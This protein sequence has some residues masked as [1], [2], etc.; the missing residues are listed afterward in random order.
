MNEE[1]PIILTEDEKKLT[2]REYFPV[3]RQLLILSLILVFLFSG[4]LVPK[5]GF[6]TQVKEE[7]KVASV[8]NSLPEPTPLSSALEVLTLPEVKVKGEAAVV[9]DVRANK[10][11]YEKNPDS[12][13]PLASIT[14][15]MT[16]LLAYELAPEDKLITI[17]SEAERQQSG[18]TLKTGE[19]FETKKL[20]DFALISSYNSA[21]Y[22]LADSIGRELSTD[23]PVGHFVAGMNVKAEELKFS[24]F[25]F[26]N[27]TGLD[28]S[29]TE[30]GAYGSAREVTFLMEYLLKE[31]PEVLRPTIR[32]TIRLYNESGDFHEA[33]NTNPL[34]KQIP[35]LLGTKTGFTDLAGG[36]LTVAFDAGFDRPI[37]VT[38]LGSSRDG[39]FSDVMSLVEAVTESLKVKQ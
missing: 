33:Q 26:L 31:Y 13:L 22:T 30:A 10:I 36:N 38:V 15:L 8:N 7:A 6:L 3:K 20:A 1:T 28:I 14:K 12:I 27:P 37:I 24:T 17:S 16:A 32:E 29:T 23:N 11:L 2:D 21:A 5:T 18:G 9:Y 35:G 25:K 19:R 4:Y 34:I 39:R